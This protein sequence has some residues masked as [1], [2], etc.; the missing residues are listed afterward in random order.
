METPQCLAMQL[1]PHHTYCL[2]IFF[3]IAEKKIPQTKFAEKKHHKRYFEGK[4]DCEVCSDLNTFAFLL[5]LL[6]SRLENLSIITMCHSLSLEYCEIG[7]SSRSIV[8]QLL[9]D[10]M[11]SLQHEEAHRVLD[12][13]S[14]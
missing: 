11:K 3:E 13:V 5:R 6:R 1:S 14:A 10:F 8:I 12:I 9:A 2:H 7:S 4:K